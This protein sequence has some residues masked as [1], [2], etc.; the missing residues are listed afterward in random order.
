[1]LRTIK[2]KKLTVKNI[3][4]INKQKNLQILQCRIYKKIRL[5]IGIKIIGIKIIR[6]IKVKLLVKINC[7]M[8]KRK[9]L[10]KQ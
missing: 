1:M 2:K 9:Q 3:L 7:W 6:I 5:H 4:E 8:I 10:K